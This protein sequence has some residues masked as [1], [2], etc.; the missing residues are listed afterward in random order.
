MLLGW[1][2]LKSRYSWEDL[3]PHLRW[4]LIF[5][6]G[7]AAMLLVRLANPTIITAEKFMDHAFIASIMRSPVVPP[8]DPWYAGGTMNIYYYGGY[9][10]MGILG[11]LT[12]VPSSVVFNLALPTVLALAAVS[13]YAIGDLLLPRFKWFPLLT[14]VLVNPAFLRLLIFGSDTG[15]SLGQ[16]PGH[17]EHHQ[18]VYPLF[19]PLGRCP[20]PRP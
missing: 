16:H 4:D 2:V 11:T 10:L 19:L 20:S 1:A 13:L 3:K 6:I 15:G 17:R 5:L 14:L 9:W 7:F 8:A 18:R 12:G